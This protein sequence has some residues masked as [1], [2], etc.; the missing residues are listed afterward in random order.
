LASHGLLV[1]AYS[2]PQVGLVAVFR[3]VAPGELL[4]VLVAANPDEAALA[5]EFVFPGGR[6]ITYDLN[7]PLDRWVMMSDSGKI[8]DREFD[9]WPLLDGRL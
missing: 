5:R 7:S 2:T 8:L 9:R 4:R 1:A 3:D 6:K